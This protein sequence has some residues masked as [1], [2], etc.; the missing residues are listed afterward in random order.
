MV[1]Q[2]LSY[3]CEKLYAK[4]PVGCIDFSK[5]ACE[6]LC[7]PLS[8]PILYASSNK[9][10]LIHFVNINSLNYMCLF[11]VTKPAIPKHSFRLFEII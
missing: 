1:M 7:N 3:F 6:F 5:E 4:P 9:R 11:P 10:K 8:E 2:K